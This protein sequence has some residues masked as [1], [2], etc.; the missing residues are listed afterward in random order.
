MSSSS[1]S[2]SSSAAPAFV[3][4]RSAEKAVFVLERSVAQTSGLIRTMLS[5][6][7][8]GQ[9]SRVLRV[10]CSGL[11]PS[12]HPLWA[13]W[14]ASLTFYATSLF[15]CARAGHAD[16][17]KDI[18]LPEITSAV[19]EKVIQYWH[20]KVKYQGSTKAIPE[21]HIP[22]ELALNVLIAADYL[23]C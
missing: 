12:P 11:P 18:E 2:S 4:L 20:Y 17:S 15:F 3:R 5:G 13:C 16:G 9:G 8:C 22:P 21:F 19:L 10:P 1:S 23:E 14:A 6:G 7:A